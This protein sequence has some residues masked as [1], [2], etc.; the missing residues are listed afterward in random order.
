MHVFLSYA[1]AD[2]AQAH[3]LATRLR[4]AKIDVWLDDEVAPGANWALE[5]GRALEEADAIVMLVSP[6]SVKS[7]WV[8]RELEYALTEPRFKDRLLPVV[9]RPTKDMPWVLSRMLPIDATEDESTAAKKVVDAL[10]ARR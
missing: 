5:V 10:R 2:T 9:V 7:P 3:D 8:Q 6:D 1:R 4:K